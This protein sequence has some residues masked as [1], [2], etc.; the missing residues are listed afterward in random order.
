M[1]FLT[2]NAKQFLHSCSQLQICQ[3]CYELE[4]YAAINRGDVPPM[5]ADNGRWHTHRM[6][7]ADGYFT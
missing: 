1:L 4:L 6:M 7:D 2:V 3:Y 5:Y